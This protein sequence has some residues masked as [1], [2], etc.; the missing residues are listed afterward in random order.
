MD[1]QHV[2]YLSNRY[3]EHHFLRTRQHLNGDS[4][5]LTDDDTL[6]SNTRIFKLG[7]FRLGSSENIYLGIR[8]CVTTL[9]WVANRDQPLANTSSLVLK[10]TER[11]ILTLYN[12]M[13]MVWS[14][15]TAKESR[16]ATV[17]LRDTGNLVLM[18]Q[19]EKVLWQSFGYPLMCLKCNI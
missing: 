3:L 8:Y 18:D 17:K 7:F 2:Y 16:N 13:S 14:L 1:L 5:F 11:G 15:N 9:V 6:V 12:N 10:N 4:R 19:H